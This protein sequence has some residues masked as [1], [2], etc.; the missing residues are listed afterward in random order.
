MES[1]DRVVIATG[2]GLMLDPDNARCL[3]RG[4]RTFCLAADPATIMR[5]IEADRSGPRPLL[6]TPDPARRIAEL[7]AARTPAYR[8]FIQIDTT[9]HTAAEVADRIAELLFVT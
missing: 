4:G 6:D 7:L 2:G 9:N 1:R 5:R 3:E 8:R